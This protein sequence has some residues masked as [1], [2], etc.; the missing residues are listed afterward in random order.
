MDGRRRLLLFLQ[1]ALF[2]SLAA[3]CRTAS[4][5]P[6]LM[7]TSL[8]HLERDLQGQLLARGHKGCRMR[9]TTFGEEVMAAAQPYTDQLADLRSPQ[10]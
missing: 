2:P 10:L 6:S 4:A 8:Q 7:S 9:L 3:Y 1:T 5:P